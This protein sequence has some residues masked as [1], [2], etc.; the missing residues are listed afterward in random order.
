MPYQN[1]MSQC[2]LRWNLPSLD[3]FAHIRM[4]EAYLW[5]HVTKR[6]CACLRLVCEFF[7]G[8]LAEWGLGIAI[9]ICIDEFESE[10][11]SGIK[12]DSGT[13]SVR[14]YEIEWLPWYKSRDCRFQIVV[15]LCRFQFAYCSFQNAV[16]ILRFA[17]CRLQFGLYL[18]QLKILI[19]ILEM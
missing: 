12:S 1:L 13:E 8:T 5:V 15:S 10:T 7:F 2:I 17:V 18:L 6:V 16:F 14:Q 19:L 9:G 11:Q 4:H 3:N